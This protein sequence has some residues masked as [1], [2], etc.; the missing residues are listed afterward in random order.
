LEEVNVNT[1][2]LME[3]DRSLLERLTSNSGQLLEDEELVHVLN[4]TKAKAAEVNQK[5]SSAADTK[6]SIAEKRE[7]C[8]CHIRL[9]DDVL[10][11]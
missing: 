10:I 5:L 6:A 3:L 2:A 11:R 4:N 1:K 7:S 8:V 9:T